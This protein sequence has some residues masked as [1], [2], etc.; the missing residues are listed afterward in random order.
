MA[1]GR[2]TPTHRDSPITDS[3]LECITS[4]DGFAVEFF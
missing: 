4:N 3:R 2:R 1:F